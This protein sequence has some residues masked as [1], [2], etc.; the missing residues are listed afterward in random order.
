[1]AKLATLR[2]KD[3]EKPKSLTFN[4]SEIDAANDALRKA[5][6]F[7]DIL[8]HVDDTQALEL[9]TLH[10]LV[11]ETISN[12]DKLYYMLNPERKVSA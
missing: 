10:V 7:V 2:R 8:T 11:W 9:E 3:E 4:L 5:W 12:L 1:M 6:A